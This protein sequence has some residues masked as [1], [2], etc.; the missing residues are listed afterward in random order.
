MC[1]TPTQAGRGG[2]A[3]DGAGAPLPAG[4]GADHPGPGV[5]LVGFVPADPRDPACLLGRAPWVFMFVGTDWRTATRPS[6]QS[7]TKPAGR[8]YVF[9]SPSLPAFMPPVSATAR[10]SLFFLAFRNNKKIEEGGC[11][12]RIEEV[13]QCLVHGAVIE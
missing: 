9:F 2:A 12:R 10:L 1:S 4:A 8:R 11:H 13:H 3:G 7:Q 6:C 5:R